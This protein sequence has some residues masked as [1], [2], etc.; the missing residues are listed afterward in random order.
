[1]EL[2]VQPDDGIKPVLEVIGKAQKSVDITIFRFDLKSM[3]KE[4][5]AARIRGVVVRALIA[6]QGSQGEKGLRQLEMR[7]LEKGIFVARTGDAFTRYHGKMMIID[8]EELHVQG[9]N[10]TALD[11]KSRSFG[12]V[13]KERHAV[14]EAI[15]LFEADTLRQEY[16]PAEDGPF[17][18]SPENAREILATFIKRAK[19]QLLIYDPKV[20]DLQMLRLIN[21]RIKAGVDVRIFGK[22]GKRGNA[23]RVQ[24]L[25]GLRL[26]VRAMVRDGDTAFVGSQSLRALELDGRREVGLIVKEPKTVKRMLDV[27][28][29]D[30]ARTDLA[31]KEAKEAKRE[32]KEKK[33]EAEL[34]EAAAR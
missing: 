7:M 32:I 17:V 15:R 4:L 1:M 9:F 11:F 25:P 33:A 3:E 13:T 22:V 28:E 21:Q 23:M 6:H 16:E 19:K 31:A 26:H 34:A 5:E 14:N 29:G 24:K 2:I 20:T 10:F 8:R 27:F 12:I 30:W 18:V